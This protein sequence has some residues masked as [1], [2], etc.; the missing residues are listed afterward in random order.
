MSYPLAFAGG[1][2]FLY[3]LKHWEDTAIL[4]LIINF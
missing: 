3:K 4:K 1:F 2:S